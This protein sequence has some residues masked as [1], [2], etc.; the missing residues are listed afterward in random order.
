MTVSLLGNFLLTHAQVFL[1]LAIHNVSEGFVMSL[2]LFLAFKSRF[3]A[4]LWAS[5]LGGLSQPAG[6]LC[7]SLWFKSHNGD[8]P[9]D[10]VYGVLFAI[11]GMPPMHLNLIIEWSS[12]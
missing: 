8:P 3:T 11:I 7:A 9:S 10:V 6:A 5:I 4:I 2:P 12:A 1:A